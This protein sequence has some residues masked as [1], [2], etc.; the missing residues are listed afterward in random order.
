MKWEGINLSTVV[1]VA[2]GFVIGSLLVNLLFG[3]KKSSDYDKE[4]YDAQMYEEDYV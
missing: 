2:L 4:T 1:E 3:K